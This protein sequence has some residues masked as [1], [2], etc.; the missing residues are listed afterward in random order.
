M[1][2]R[3][4]SIVHGNF[5]SLVQWVSF[6]R[7]HCTYT[8]VNSRCLP[9][10]KRYGSQRQPE[11]L[12]FCASG[13]DIAGP[14]QRDS[15]TVMAFTDNMR[16]WCDRPSPASRAEVS[17]MRLAST[18]WRCPIHSLG[19]RSSRTRSVSYRGRFS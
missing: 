7:Q 10:F 12:H 6:S 15:Y 2:G 9:P 19:S 1:N 16:V 5:A 18:W 11:Q 13:L 8:C 3:T 4:L 14:S 17:H